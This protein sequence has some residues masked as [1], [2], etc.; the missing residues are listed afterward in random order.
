MV[1]IKKRLRSLLSVLPMRSLRARIFVIILAVG[2]IPSVLMRYAIVNNYE[3][4]AVEQR[5]TDVQNQL[6]ILANHLISNHYLSNYWSD[7]Q[8]YRNS[9]EVIDAELELL[10]N[11]YEGRVMIINGNF[12]VVKDTYGIS[13][14][15]TIISEEVIRCFLGEN[16][17]NYDQEHGYIELTIPIIDSRTDAE[18]GESGVIKGVMLTSIS[19][20]SIVTTME[21]LNRKALIME[22]LMILAIVVLAMVL[23]IAMTRPFNRVTEAINEVQAGY[24]D[25]R[26]SVRGYME[27]T[28]IMDAFNQL[29]ERMNVL[30]DSRQEFV[31]NVSHELKTPM[32]SIKVLADSLMMQDDVPPEL[33][34][35]FMEDIVSEIDRENRIITDLLAL[36]KMDKKVQELNIVSLNINELTELI[37]KRLRPLARKK[38]VEVVYESLRPV[39][40]E[41]D[42]VK[43]TLIMTNLVENAIKYNKDHGW[44]KVV[45]D[46]DHQFFTLQ[47]SDSGIGIPEDSLAHIYERFYR[48]DKSHSREIGGTGLGLAITKSAVLMHRGSIAVTST[49]GEGTSFLVKIP[50]IYIAQ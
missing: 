41:A 16:M 4:R 9:K 25:S 37:L 6:M 40:A 14:G 1:K 7:E 36:V 34:R 31:A 39:V 18:T 45:L 19:N 47:V 20:S 30:D 29:I 38:D 3:E 23:S 13:E 11:L 2:I 27:T 42:E 26:I 32:A 22:M 5:V 28:H 43:M 48:A 15:R 50:L 33:Y 10:S 17:S 8:A 21:V 24:S 12:K 35:E 46:A 44:V 49:E